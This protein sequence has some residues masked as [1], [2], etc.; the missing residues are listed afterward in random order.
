M[1]RLRHGCLNSLRIKHTH[2]RIQYEQFC[3]VAPLFRIEESA[4]P[5]LRSFHLFDRRN[6]HGLPHSRLGEVYESNHAVT[7]A[8]LRTVFWNC[9]GRVPAPQ[10]VL[11]GMI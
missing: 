3:K 4:V 1:P 5:G 7:F 10:K 9:G 11:T 6:G 2:P 8:S